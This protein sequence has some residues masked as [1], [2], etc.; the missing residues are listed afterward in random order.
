MA[1]Q[2]VTELVNGMVDMEL[3]V[4]VDTNGELCWVDAAM[5]DSIAALSVTGFALGW[6]VEPP[7]GDD[8]ATGCLV[9]LLSGHSVRRF[10]AEPDSVRR[11]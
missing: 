11:I 8:T 2:R 9:A 3:L 5:V 4:R 6:R 7:G 10:R 1:A